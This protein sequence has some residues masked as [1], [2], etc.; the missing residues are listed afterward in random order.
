MTEAACG[1]CLSLTGPLCVCLLDILNQE[2][3]RVHRGINQTLC[4][5]PP[6]AARRSQVVQREVHT[7]QQPQCLLPPH[8]QVKS[9]LTKHY[10]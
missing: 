3:Y 10:L 7:G 4:I 2:Q 8:S 9:E 1:S 6:P 5:Q